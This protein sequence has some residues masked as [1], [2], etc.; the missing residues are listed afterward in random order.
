[1]FQMDIGVGSFV[2]SLGLTSA[3]PFLRPD[4]PTITVLS[5]VLSGLR[6]SIPVW[7]LGVVRVLMV[8]GVEYPVSSTSGKLGPQIRVFLRLTQVV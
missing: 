1:M 2:F 6:K 4:S 7:I 5:T 3:A 8:K